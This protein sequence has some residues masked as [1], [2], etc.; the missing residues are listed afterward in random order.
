[1]NKASIVA[2]V[3]LLATSITSTAFAEP[4]RTFFSETAKTANDGSISL[5][6]EYQFVKNGFGTGLRIGA[7]DGEVLLNVTNTGFAASSIGYK[8]MINNDIVAYG[9]LSHRNNEDNNSDSFTDIAIGAAY[10]LS[11][12]NLSFNFNGEFITDDSESQWG[13]DNTLFLKAAMILPIK[14]TKFNT[15]FIAEVA[16][17][18]NDF[19]DTLFALGLRWKPSNRLTTDLI[20]HVDDGNNET[21]GIPG[22]VKLNF[23]F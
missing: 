8:K 2:I 11:L 21:S 6:L 1:M 22:Y 20:F 19:I 18:N 12:K 3:S 13:G 23:V 7:F 14:S 17:E 9:I 4:T 16:L 10:T 15:S 5:D